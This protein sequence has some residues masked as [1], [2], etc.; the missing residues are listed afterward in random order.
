MIMPMKYAMMECANVTIVVGKP[1]AA[2]DPPRMP[3]AIECSVMMDICAAEN[4][5]WETNMVTRRRWLTRKGYNV[6]SPSG[7]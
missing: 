6:V 4:R 3:A 2:S 1:A 5:L 7:E